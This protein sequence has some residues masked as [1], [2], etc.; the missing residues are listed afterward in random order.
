MRPLVFP[1][2]FAR[3]PASDSAGKAIVRAALQPGEFRDRL[4]R[5]IFITDDPSDR[6]GLLEHTLIKVIAARGRRQEARA[7]D[8]QGRRAPLLQQ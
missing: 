2:G 5:D 3:N 8:S 4:T 7:R 1:Y 6:V